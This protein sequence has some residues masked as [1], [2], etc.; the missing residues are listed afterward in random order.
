MTAR[1]LETL[2]SAS[3]STFSEDEFSIPLDLSDIINICQE[4]NKLGYNIQNQ[5]ENILEVGVIES[6][7]SGILKQQSL[8]HIKDFLKAVCNNP[9]FGDCCSQSIE[10]IELIDDFLSQDITTSNL[11]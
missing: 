10:L 6:I 8:P 9:Y 3:Q 4:Y 1:K 7:N 2:I 11:N 5:I